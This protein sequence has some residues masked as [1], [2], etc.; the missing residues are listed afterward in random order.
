MTK[1]TNKKKII[2]LCVCMCMLITAIASLSVAYFTDTDAE[3]NTFTVGNVQIDLIESQLHRVNAGIANGK[4]ST[5]PLWTPD[6]TMEGTAANTPDKENSTWSGQFFSDEQIEADAATYKEDGGYFDTNSQNMMPG[7]NVRKN[8]YVKNT[9]NSDAYVRI[10]ALVP[11][12]LFTVLD[13]GP[14]Y[15]TSTA[16]KDGVTS[17]AVEYYNAHNYSMEGCPASMKATRNGVEY[18]VFDFTY[19]NA[20]KPGALTFWNPWGNI[21][22]DKNATSEDLEGVDS[23]DVI[24]EADA[25]QAQGF[26]DANAAF[27]AFDAQ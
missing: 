27:A 13:N 20:L 4:T 19:A 22:I 15:W 12:S 7:S 11:V 5:S 18:Y 25:I 3:T 24:F 14:S 8:P 6:Q 16:L 17:K 9:G 26:S 23:F 2:S 1:T 10:R 21:A